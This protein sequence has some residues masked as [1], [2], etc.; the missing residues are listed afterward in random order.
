NLGRTIAIDAYLGNIAK[1][2]SASLLGHKSGI[3][4]EVK[5]EP[6]E[7]DSDRAVAFG[8]L[9]NELATN[10]IKHAFPDGIGRIVLSVEQAGDQIELTVADNGVGMKDEKIAKIPQRRGSDYVAIFARQ[11]GGTIAASRPE[12]AGTTVRIRFPLLLVPP[13]DAER[14]E[15]GSDTSVST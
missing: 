12:G 6:L 8:L 1:T 5:A 9:V 15:A 2:M 7:I 13:S 10:A 14:L 4:I 11:L 3:E